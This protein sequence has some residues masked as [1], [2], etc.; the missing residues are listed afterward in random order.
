MMNSVTNKMIAEYAELASE[1]LDKIPITKMEDFDVI[2]LAL[3]VIMDTNQSVNIE[4]KI[5]ER[6]SN[7]NDYKEIMEKVSDLQEI[8]D[9]EMNFAKKEFYDLFKQTVFKQINLKIKEIDSMSE[10][11]KLA[12]INEYAINK[13]KIGEDQS[14]MKK[15]KAPE[16][17]SE[18]HVLTEQQWLQSLQS[19]RR[20]RVI[21][22]ATPADLMRIQQQM[23]ILLEMEAPLGRVG[24]EEP[25]GRVGRTVNSIN[26][27]VRGFFSNSRWP[28]G[29]D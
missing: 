26:D 24:I 11:Q 15:S 23:S 1:Y 25:L 20:V 9:P 16:E 7:L 28:R 29:N 21:T 18:A 22:P 14:I 2:S 5:K 12:L 3:N 6:F 27:A 19:Q 17:G 13:I 8:L 10:P 4:E